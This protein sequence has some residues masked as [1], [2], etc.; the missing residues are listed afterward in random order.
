MTYNPEKPYLN[1]LKNLGERPLQTLASEYLHAL[2]DYQVNLYKEDK[3]EVLS[4]PPTVFYWFK[5]IS[6]IIDLIDG[7]YMFR[8]L[9]I[10][11]E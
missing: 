9:E 6:N 4:V 7:K 11:S 2:V 3:I 5:E 10:T 1:F 8:G